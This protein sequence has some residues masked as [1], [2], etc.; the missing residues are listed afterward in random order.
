VPHHRAHQRPRPEHLRTL[1]AV[2]HSIAPPTTAIRST[3]RRRP[4]HARLHVNVA[5]FTR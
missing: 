4:D 3:T 2:G 5:A 1:R